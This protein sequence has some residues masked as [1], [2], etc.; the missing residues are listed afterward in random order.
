MEAEV[1]TFLKIQLDLPH[2]VTVDVLNIQLNLPYHL[3]IELI[4]E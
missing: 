4:F 1:E 3:T 2:H